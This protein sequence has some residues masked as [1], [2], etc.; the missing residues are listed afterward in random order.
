MPAR[1]IAAVDA[2]AGCRVVD[3]GRHDAQ[4]KV[5]RL[6]PPGPA[7]LVAATGGRDEQPA[8]GGVEREQ[9]DVGY[10]EDDE[11]DGE[12][13][14]DALAALDAG[15]RIDQTREHAHG[16]EDVGCVGEAERDDGVGAREVDEGVRGGEEEE[17]HERIAEDPAL[18]LAQ[19]GPVAGG[20]GQHDHDARGDGVDGH[21]RL[22]HEHVFHLP[23]RLRS[24]AIHNNSAFYCRRGWASRCA[25]KVTVRA[26]KVPFVPDFGT[27]R[28]SRPQR[29]QKRTRT[30]QATH[31]QSQ[32]RGGQRRVTHIKRF[33]LWRSP[34][35]SGSRTKERKSPPSLPKRAKPPACSARAMTLAVPTPTPS[36]LV[37]RSL[38]C[39]FR[40]ILPA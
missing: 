9:H 29:C 5:G 16:G 15:G 12:H 30:V 25:A 8:E 14:G 31:A 38:P 26:K 35:E 40:R 28:A 11:H 19:H 22:G 33:R 32:A 17:D 24:W 36:C 27:A 34:Y 1:R 18:A 7:L 13:H 39:P 21:P 2:D 4:G 10:A 37:E 6:A 23:R 3:C 20:D